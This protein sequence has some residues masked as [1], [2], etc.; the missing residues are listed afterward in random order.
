MKRT[1]FRA[2]LAAAALSLAACQEGN[3]GRDPDATVPAGTQP[4][5]TAQQQADPQTEPNTAQ[6]NE[7][8]APAPGARSYDDCV[9]DARAKAKSDP[10][11]EVLERTCHSL[12]GAPRP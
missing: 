9:A 1:I 6:G 2:A 3:A 12:R 8:Q 11:R 5:P 4:A 10:E 7:A